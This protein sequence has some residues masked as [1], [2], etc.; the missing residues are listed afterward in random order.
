MCNMHAIKNFTQ[1]EDREE[2][3]SL[4]SSQDDCLVRYFVALSHSHEMR[5]HLSDVD[6]W[7]KS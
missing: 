5:G 7:H 4:Y 6:G 2:E 3:E 1:N